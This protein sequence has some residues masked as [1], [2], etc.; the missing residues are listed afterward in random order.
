MTDESALL[1]CVLEN[2]ADDFPRLV[3]CDFWE[4]RG[5]QLERAEFIKTQIA[6]WAEHPRGGAPDLYAD[7]DSRDD[8]I[9]KHHV[10]AL[11]AREREIAESLGETWVSEMLSIK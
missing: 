10:L 2:P 9:W 11:Q 1:Q 7:P 4:E 5:E 3:L 8:Q 6:L